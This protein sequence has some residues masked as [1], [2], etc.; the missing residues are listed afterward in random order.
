MRPFFSLYTLSLSPIILLCSPVLSISKLCLRCICS[1]S[2]FVLPVAKLR[3]EAVLSHL[4]S[5]LHCYGCYSVI[6]EL[7]YHNKYTGS[8][9]IAY[10]CCKTA[11]LNFKSCTNRT[12]QNCLANSDALQA[13]G[14][15]SSVDIKCLCSNVEYVNTIACCLDTKCSPADQQSQ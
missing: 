5:W 7:C 4:L 8:C 14:S 10:L 11:T 15:C 9:W 12:Q 3:H 2:T 13:Q 1:F 6:L